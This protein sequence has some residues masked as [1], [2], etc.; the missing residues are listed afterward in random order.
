MKRPPLPDAEA[1]TVAT[2]EFDRNVVVLA[3]AGTGKTSLL[4]ERLLVALA[5]N[6]TGVREF[7]A[8]TFTERASGEMRERLADGLARLRRYASGTEPDPNEAAGR[9]FAFVTGPQGVPPRLVAERALAALHELDRATVS[10]IHGFCS[11]I[12]HA[13][14]VSALLD[15]SFDVD[16]GTRFRVLFDARWES[17]L[18]AEL[19]PA[20]ARPELWT[21]L[22]GRFTIGEIEEAAR[23][24]AGWRV[25]EAILERPYAPADARELFAGE[26][27][28][29]RRDLRALAGL[30]R[31]TPPTQGYLAALERALAAFEADGLEGLHAALEAAGAVNLEKDPPT[32]Q[33][34]SVPLDVRTAYEALAKDTRALLRSLL[35]VDEAA[36]AD[37]HGAVAPFA[38]EIRSTALREGHVGFDG[39]LTLTRDLLRDRPEVR[40]RVRR[41]YRMIL[42]DEFQDTDPVQYEI[43]LYLAEAPGGSARDPFAARLAPGRLFIVGDAKQSIYRFRG[44]DYAAYRR[45]IE[46]VASE[47]G[48]T[49]DLVANFRSRA[50]ILDAVNRL[51][52]GPGT[53]WTEDD[54]QPPY[55]PIRPPEAPAAAPPATELWT[56][57][58]SGGADARRLDE[59]RAIAA[60]IRRGID[61]GS[62]ARFGDVLVLLRA[63]TPL[64]LYLRALREAGVP[65]VASGGKTF[66]D[67][68]EIEQATALLR[69]VARPADTVALLA[70]LRSPAGGV[71]DTELFAHASGG[72]RL[73]ADAS[74]DADRAPRLA[75]ALRRLAE[76][77]RTTRRLPAGDAVI[78]IL[79]SSRTYPLAAFAF[80]G[81]Q[82]IANLRKLA[83]TAADLARDG[84]LTLSQVLDLLDERRGTETERESPLADEGGE[85]VRVL[86]VHAAK[87]LECPWVFV[88]DLARQVTARRGADV[89]ADLLRH[90]GDSWLALRGETVVSTASV[91][92][93]RRNRAHE[94]AESLRLL[95]VAATR[96]KD[97]LV[98][99][100]SEAQGSMPWLDAL[101]AWGY[102]RTSLPSDGEPLAGGTVVHRRISPSEARAAAPAVPVA[103]PDSGA[104]E[105]TVARLRATARPPFAAPS[106]AAHAGR[107]PAGDAARERGVALAA[108]AAVH[109]LLERFDPASPERWRTTLAR[110]ARVAASEHDADLGPVAAAVES[111]LETFLRS[112]F[113]ARLARGRILDR[114]VP[115]LCR[116]PD[117]RVWR[118]SIDL[119]LEEPGE[120][121]VV[122]DYKTDDDPAGAVE[123]YGPQLRAY[124]DAARVA[125][126]LARPPRGELWM[127]RAGIALPIDR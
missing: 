110:A 19:G 25:P 77:E 90:D 111:A 68:P 11:E 113:P 66:L 79:E 33:A 21:R 123:R 94:R 73:A 84:R 93:E 15:P 121:I 124:V 89:A 81:P 97:R 71:P 119:L 30:G 5:T 102:D 14:A 24:L 104:W 17:W 38:R 72:G 115:M 61:D 56:V 69:A 27:R 82:R 80:E 106:A 78:E 6:R 105:A 23:V 117:G 52:E 42:V 37:L 53:R 125:L 57:R 116:H 114:E 95:Y 64:G 109:A 22:L 16:D 4:V 101:A 76:L 118:G 103:V 34:K 99:L 12:L 40:E 50:S 58:T 100:A 67:R 126:R 7:A 32:T 51:F 112:P 75:E 70:Y 74:V 3:G 41:K 13:H 26:S 86:T 1:R 18:S 20:A 44:A 9:A 31:L 45:A 29:R 55:V 96:A 47:G 46:R 63:F 43:V 48:A 49:L 87:G 62:L 60:A 88:P 59:G 39:L 28:E 36:I 8:I 83:A 54:A 85:A 92:L 2:T 122:V 98:L 35:A 127:V 91:A 65:F 108:G 107:A 120:G 10:T